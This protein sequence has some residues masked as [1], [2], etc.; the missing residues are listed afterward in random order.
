MSE[1]YQMKEV[2][3]FN[4]MKERLDYLKGRFE[5]IQPVEA[6][7]PKVEEPKVEKPKKARKGKRKDGKVQAE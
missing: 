4:T 6:E 1:D 5:E 7:E 3:H 2:V